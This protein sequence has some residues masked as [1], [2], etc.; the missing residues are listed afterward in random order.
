MALEIVKEV[1]LILITGASGGLGGYVVAELEKKQQSAIAVVRSPVS[2]PPGKVTFVNGDLRDYKWI[3]SLFERFP[4]RKVIHLAWDRGKG[5]DRFLKRQRHNLQFTENLLKMAQT[6]QVPSFVFISSLN[7]GLPHKN[8]Y[9]RDKEEAEKMISASSIPH[10]TIYRLSSLFG[11]GVRAYLNN[12]AKSAMEK[13]IIFLLGENPLHFQP[14]FAGEAARILLEED[15][16]GTYY[17][18]GPEVW[19][20]ED[21][22]R[23]VERIRH[24]RLKI[25]RLPLKTIA[26]FI[27]LGVKFSGLLGRIQEEIRALNQD[28]MYRGPNELRGSVLYGDYLKNMLTGEWP[29]FQRRNST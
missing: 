9:A 13:K 5:M 3:T 24:I 8:Q 22:V 2:L 23:T 6:F 27:S 25:F 21:L 29:D 11:I 12:L 28:K 7:A 17:I 14:L 1:P 16:E 20:D 4:F 19:S 26:H 10:K 18:V 15:K